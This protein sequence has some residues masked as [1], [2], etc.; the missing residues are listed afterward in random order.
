MIIIWDDK[1]YIE[2]GIDSLHQ[3]N[4]KIVFL[5]VYKVYIFK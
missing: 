1:V 4:Q 3:R 5:Y 2:T